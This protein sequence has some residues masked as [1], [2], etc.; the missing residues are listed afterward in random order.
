MYR[1]VVG[2]CVGRVI[3]GGGGQNCNT[4]NRDEQV[5]FT[6]WIGILL[7]TLRFIPDVVL[8]L[9]HIQNKLVN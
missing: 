4:Y 2:G 5:W 9:F 8:L 7:N 3:A 1:V 6:L